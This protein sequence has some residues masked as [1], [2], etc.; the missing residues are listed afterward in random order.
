M[1]ARAAQFSPFAALTGY[2]DEIDETARLTEEKMDISFDDEKREGLDKT[3][4]Y[5][6]E[7]AKENVL[8]AVEYFVP[9]KKKTG[10]EYVKMQGI[11][12]RIDNE[13]GMLMFTDGHKILLKD[14]Y[15]IRIEA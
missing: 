3:I 11:F 9:D 6:E 4:S 1:D 7:H 8:I 14:I 5:L 12:K 2:D 13:D 15:N 10:G